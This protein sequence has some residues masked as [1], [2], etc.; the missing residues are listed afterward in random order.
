MAYLVSITARA[1]RD[2]LALYNEINAEQSNHA[3][4]WYAGMKKAV[5]SLERLPHRC[6]ATPERADLRHLLYGRKPNVYRIVYRIVETR[7]RVEVLHN[8]HGARRPI[9]PSGLA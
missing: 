9:R 7:K 5:L 2:L 4:K 3:A 1:E 6:P 8:R